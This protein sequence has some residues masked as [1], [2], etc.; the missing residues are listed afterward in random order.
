MPH[1]R[2]A[3]LDYPGLLP[4]ERHQG[5]DGEGQVDVVQ[6]PLHGIANLAALHGAEGFPGPARPNV[7]LKGDFL[8]IEAVVIVRDGR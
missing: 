2:V 3:V 1:S 5:V 4:L 8:A 6:R 7:D